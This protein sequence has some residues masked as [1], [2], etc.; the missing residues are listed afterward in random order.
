MMTLM[1]P[2]SFGLA[3]LVS[4]VSAPAVVTHITPTVELVPRASA[5]RSLLEG[6]SKFFVRNIELDGD[7]M[8]E[9]Q[10]RAGW[11]PEERNF[12]VFVGRDANGDKVGDALLLKVDSRHGP[13]ALAVG[14]DA[15]GA[16]SGV[17]I[18]HAT[19]ETVPW[20]GEAIKAGLLD[21]YPGCTEA[22]VGQ[23][24]EA[25]KSEVGRMPLYMAQRATVGVQRALVL[26][27]I[28]AS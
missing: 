22:T 16:L 17:I 27:S 4:L 18:T 7:A 20:V 11:K 12:R 9:L 15:A 26:S 21:E 23:A 14:F 19:E 13:L 5:V 10:R 1:S 25:V 8:A 24:L 2:I 3:A 28:S 6:S